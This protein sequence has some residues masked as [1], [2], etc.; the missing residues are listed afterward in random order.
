MHALPIP[1][2]FDNNTYTTQNHWGCSHVL[3]MPSQFSTQSEGFHRSC[4]LFCK[5]C[6]DAKIADLLSYGADAPVSEFLIGPQLDPFEMPAQLTS[7]MLDT[8]I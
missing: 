2:C 4:W 1:G 5:C 7:V 6:A 8:P 3:L